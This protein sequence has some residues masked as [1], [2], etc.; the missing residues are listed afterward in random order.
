[1]LT[2][3]LAY[4]NM[5]DSLARSIKAKVEHFQ[6]STLLGTYSYNDA[7][8]NIHVDR[9]AASGKFF[10]FGVAQKL[11][12]KLTDKNRQ[13]TVTKGDKL[14]IYFS[15]NA[16]E[17]LKVGPD[18]T[19]DDV[20]RDEKTNG[21]TIIALD[22]VSELSKHTFSELGTQTTERTVG[23][24]LSASAAILGLS[25]I[26]NSAA[27]GSIANIA[28]IPNYDGT[29][30]L[31]E[32]L[33]DIAEV[34]QAIYFCDGSS[35]YMKELR[36]T[37][38]VALTVSKNHYFELTT[39]EA[40]VL[41]GI[42]H[43]TEL[44][45]NVQ[46]GNGTVQV[47]R[48]NAFWATYGNIGELLTESLARVN[49][50]TFIPYSCSW[51][52]NFAAQIGDK[53]AI[54]DKTGAVI[55]TYILNDSYE[56][57]GGFKQTCSWTY[58]Q[59]KV[60]SAAPATISEKIGQTSAKVDKVN[61][62]ITLLVTSVEAQ[63]EQI[64]QLQVTTDG[65][66]GKVTEMGKQEQKDVEALEER[67]D[68]IS[69]EA[70]MKLDAKGVEIVVAQTI[71]DGVD[72]VVTTAKNY[73]FDDS[74]LNISSTDSNISTT[75]TE[76]GMRIYRAGEEVLTAD[77]EGVKAEDLHATTF[78]IIGNTSRLEDRESRTACYWIGG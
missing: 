12:L 16:S 7:L 8:Q 42:A 23:A 75:I 71:A 11:T 26:S 76:D 33:D 55:H 70:S 29:E 4:L 22:P 18:F 78:L 15:V 72:K 31:R 61:Q 43:V 2:T 40:H 48:D 28:G 27:W 19:V 39:E 20:K 66:T 17:Y 9:T 44:G 35:L 64:S 68:S 24:I 51:R 1:M 67:L 41:T 62:E 54:Q 36:P 65:I 3:D 46:A 74:G 49:G 63:S 10:G 59:E 34:I 77:N 50:L 53:I 30:T 47:V 25:V 52:G 73:T 37:D 60:E 13:K 6:G 21:L 57:S 58:E 14:K 69:K 38:K 32:V 45:D 56:Y 5:N